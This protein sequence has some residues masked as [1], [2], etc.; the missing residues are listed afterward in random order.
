MRIRVD[1][2]V[3]LAPPPAR[4]NAVLLIEPFALAV[5][6][7]AR[8]VDQK[9]QWLVTV[10]SLR[11]DREIAATAAQRG[12]VG[13]GN[14]DLQQAGDRSQQTLSLSQRLME[15]QPE[16][17]ARLDGDRRVDRLTTP[18]A[19][20]RGLPRCDGIVG[21]PHR[22]ASAPDQRGVVLRPVRNSVFG[23]GYLVAAAFVELVRHGSH[24]RRTHTDGPAAASNMPP[25]LATTSGSNGTTCGLFAHQCGTRPFAH[26]HDRVMV[27]STPSASS[28]SNA[29]A[30]RRS[31]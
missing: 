4:T 16:R 21:Q 22:Q 18:L 19:G 29:R 24:Q 31:W 9:M 11:Q 25:S 6:L 20:S 12:M 17:E 26:L 7:Q 2:K 3:Q 5:N 15:D 14:V 10:N 23:P 1:T 27:T 13:D 28:S 8:A 30:V